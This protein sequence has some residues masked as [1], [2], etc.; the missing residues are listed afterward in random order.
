MLNRKKRKPTIV[1]TNPEKRKQ[2]AP[3]LL[4]PQPGNPQ[5]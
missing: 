2:K 3:I 4:L 5:G 1:R